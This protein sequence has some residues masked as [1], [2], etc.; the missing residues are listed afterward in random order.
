M[1]G[2]CKGPQAASYITRI[3]SGLV[4]LV[5]TMEVQRSLHSAWKVMRDKLFYTQLS[6]TKG[7]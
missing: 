5:N 4:N 2:G 1:K 3:G 7:I 6:S